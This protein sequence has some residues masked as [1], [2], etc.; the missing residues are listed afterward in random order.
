MISKIKN[1]FLIS[2]LLGVFLF[3][4]SAQAQYSD[5]NSCLGQIGDPNECCKLFT[6]NPT[7]AEA[8]QFVSYQ[9]CMSW[10]GDK[11]LCC[12]D[13]PENQACQSIL[14]PSDT[15]TPPELND[16]DGDVRNIPGLSETIAP[17]QNSPNGGGSLSCPSGTTLQNGL[18]VPQGGPTGGFA[19]SKTLMGLLTEILKYLLYLAGAIA[20]L[21]IV[22]GGFQ[23]ITSAGNEEQAEKG[24]NTLVNAI[25]GLVV[26]IMSYAIIQVIANAVTKTPGT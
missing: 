6:T 15:L 16:T 19:N 10:T 7:C 3:S 24:K 4:Q 25:I 20:V 17:I 22:I 21:F 2:T 12:H 11:T 8:S 1:I 18:C 23:Y 5:Y 9:S 13:F 26:I 14:T